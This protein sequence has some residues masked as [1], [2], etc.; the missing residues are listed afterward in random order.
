MDEDH[1]RVAWPPHSYENI[2][3][4]Q[5]RYESGELLSQI[6]IQTRPLPA[7]VHKRQFVY[8]SPRPPCLL[9]RTQDRSPRV[10]SRVGAQGYS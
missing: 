5:E 9:I 10:A 4:I 6:G 3:F 8:Q 2:Y 1:T 7:L